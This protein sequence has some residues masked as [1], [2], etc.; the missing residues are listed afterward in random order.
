MEASVARTCE[1]DKK[2]KWQPWNA[3]VGGHNNIR[4]RCSWVKDGRL[5][6]RAIV[7]HVWPSLSVTPG[8]TILA[9]S[10]AS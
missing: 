6:I 10:K 3:A 4:K 1:R 9:R 7:N 8:I 2:V 5:T